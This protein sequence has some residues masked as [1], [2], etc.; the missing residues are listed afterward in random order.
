MFDDEG[1]IVHNATIRDLARPAEWLAP[2]RESPVAGRPLVDASFALN[3]ALG[4]LDVGGYHVVN[5]A[6]HLACALLLFGLVRRTL[7]LSSLAPRFGARAASLAFAVALL[8]TVHPLASEPV[9]Y[10]TERTESMMAL[11]YLATL[12][13]SVRAAID[14]GARW[15]ALAVLACAAGMACKESM[16]TAP[17]MVALFDRAFVF[18]S[19]AAAWR[20][21]RAWYGA[22]AATWIVLAALA[23]SHPRTSS[24]GFAT[25]PTSLWMYVLNQTVIVTR[26]LRLT[27]W[28]RGLVLYYGWPQPTTLGDVWPYVVVLAAVGVAAAV[29]ALR[30]RR[31]WFLVVW[32][33]IT[34]APSSSLVPIGSEVG[35]ER[36]M[37]LP[38]MG[39][40]AMAVFA[41]VEVW[42]RRANRAVAAAPNGH[43]RQVREGV[44]ASLGMLFV[45]V[46]LLLA[47]ATIQRTSEYS[48]PLTM[49]ETLVARWPGPGAETLLGTELAT[50]GRHDEAVAHL[51][52][53]AAGMPPARFNLGSELLKTGHQDEGIAEL[54][55]FVHDEPRLD[56]T[57][58]ARILIGRAEAE[59]GRWPAAIEAFTAAT[60]AKPLN[61]DAQ[62]QLAEAL[63]GAG[64]FDEA[65]I[66]YRRFLALRPG[67]ASGWTGLGI[68]LATSGHAVDAAAAFSHAAAIDPGD[69]HFQVNYARA[70]VDAGRAGD[71][72]APAERAVALAPTD[73]V[74]L[75]VLGQAYAGSGRRADARIAFTRA[76]AIDPAYSP[77]RAGLER[78]KN[79][80]P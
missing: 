70:L 71:A 38:L 20:R 6:I 12:Y 27:V 10:L 21:R 75:D 62:G 73:P 69:A 4:G 59:A 55:T 28:P 42:D 74:A 66:R 54:K 61:A 80:A 13:A 17:V 23:A 1:A 43:V 32:V 26:Y 60:E 44:P 9:D 14:P 25:A 7:E 49:A 63:A 68:A 56:T 58:D 47:I 5:L 52:V 39:L 8:W 35:A 57:T 78:I 65:V 45:P 3:Y 50:A 51:R 72:V 77:A 41:V 48:S 36:R 46:A 40:V 34:L 18:D 29:A 15:L 67:D 76:L 22:L 79:E 30:W 11:A 64:R 2:V 33:V 19:L 24:A 31:V 37:Y 53:A 16:V